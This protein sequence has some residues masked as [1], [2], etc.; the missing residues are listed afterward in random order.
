MPGRPARGGGPR[1]R[2]PPRVSSSGSASGSSLVGE[3]V[4]LDPVG[5]PG[6]PDAEQA[7]AA[8]GVQLAQQAAGD[9]RDLPAVVGG[10]GQRGRAAEGGE[11][12]QPHLD[13]DRAPGEAGLAQPLGDLGRLPVQQ[14]LEQPLVDVVGLVG[15]LDADRLRLPLGLH[16]AVVLGAGQRV[17][18]AAVAAAEHPHQLVLG[19]PLEVLH[20]V[21]PSRRSRSAVAG[22]TPGMTVTCIGRSR[23]CSM[24][25]ATTTRPSGLSRSLAILAI[26][27]EE[28]MPTEPVTPPVTSSTRSLSSRAERADRG[29]A[30]G[31]AGRRPR[32]RRTP[33]RARA[34][35]PAG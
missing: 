12:V 27:F 4:L 19:E 10:L 17:E 21:T 30:S 20:G 11:V 24:P 1:L 32:G 22:P 25:G 8:R 2:R 35:R 33:R 6:D 3:E 23:S 9:P 18:A 13:R 29:D 14:R 16:R 28:P 7:Y 5:E 15:V 31:R 34:A 26:S